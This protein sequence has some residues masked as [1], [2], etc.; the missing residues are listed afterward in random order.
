VYQKQQ[1][2]QKA[3]AAE[4]AAAKKTS[5]NKKEN[6]SA[7]TVVADK[8]SPSDFKALERKIQKLEQ[9]VS[10]IEQSFAALTF[11]SVAFDD[12][13]KKLQATKKDLAEA[14][15]LWEAQA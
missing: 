1:D 10:K 6:V 12:A 7:S 15:S 11:G 14:V 2:A 9:E 5:V 13:Q 4:T 3:Q 8:L